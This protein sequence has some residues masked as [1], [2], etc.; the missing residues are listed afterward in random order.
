MG[1][2]FGKLV[3]EEKLRWATP[4]SLMIDP[5]LRESQILQLANFGDTLCMY[6]MPNQ[7]LLFEYQHFF[8][9][10]GTWTIEFG[11]GEF[12]NAAVNIHTN[13]KLTG[14]Y[15]VEQKRKTDEMVQRMEKV[16]GARGYSLALRNCEHLSRYIFW[17]SWTCLQMLEGASMATTLV[18]HML[19]EQ[20]LMVNTLPH[21]LRELV[22][23]PEPLYR[24]QLGACV[25]T[26]PG[27]DES[28][29]CCVCPTAV[30]SLVATG[31]R[32]PSLSCV[33]SQRSDPNSNPEH[34]DSDRC[35]PNSERC[36][37]QPN[38][39]VQLGNMVNPYVKYIGRPDG[40]AKSDMGAYNVLIVGPTGCGKSHL[41]NMI[42]NMSVC[43]SDDSA[44]SVTKMI[45]I[46]SGEAVILGQKRKVNIIDTVG[47]CDTHLSPKEALAVIKDKVKLNFLHIDR[48]IVMCSGR[49]EGIHVECAKKIMGWLKYHEHELN[50]TFIYG[51]ADMVRENMRETNLATMCNLLETGHAPSARQSLKKA[52]LPSV[53]RA[54]TRTESNE[55]TE[56]D[57]NNKIVCAMPPNAPFEDVEEELHRVLD[58]T[59]VPH[60][61][62]GRI[63]KKDYST[64]AQ[65]RIPLEESWC[66][67][68]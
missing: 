18:R 54:Q 44:E 40:L 64:D 20:K 65:L 51:K 48:V 35:L 56:T 59:F 61:K 45:E 32:F 16:C 4:H 10:D 1:G 26:R 24:V 30:L 9:T 36:S 19:H 50:F 34:P 46:T 41:I 55:V 39:A 2:S 49:V 33:F 53:I 6:R 22:G 17:G 43:L 58:K 31:G 7:F 5:E 60:M 3:E 23:K 38:M 28:G 67:I 25:R 21:E 66:S 27:A 12:S 63:E 37:G 52:W 13:P 15:L 57:F 8:V 14:A 62:L 47:F 68:L 42:Y 29:L 11:G